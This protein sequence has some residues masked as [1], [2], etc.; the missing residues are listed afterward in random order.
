VLNL[1]TLT[2]AYVVQEEED[3]DRLDPQRH[4]ISN[5]SILYP[6]TAP[7]TWTV[8]LSCLFAINGS[9]HRVLTKV[10]LDDVLDQEV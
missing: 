3:I 1:M 4:A 6:D 7:W 10:G 9:N 2:F 8:I 5:A